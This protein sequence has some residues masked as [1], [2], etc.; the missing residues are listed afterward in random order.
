MEFSFYLESQTNCKQNVSK[1]AQD[2]DNNHKRN[3]SFFFLKLKALTLNV[4]EDLFI[5]KMMFR[6]INIALRTTSPHQWQ[7]FKISRL[8]EKE[9]N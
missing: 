3:F 9:R 8:D 7:C 4:K 5:K 2:Q 1:K 6:N